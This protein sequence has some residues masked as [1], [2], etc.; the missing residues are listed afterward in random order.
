MRSSCTLAMQRLSDGCVRHLE[1]ADCIKVR[2]L[3]GT[4]ECQ[5]PA[6][7]QA[8]GLFCGG[9]NEKTGLGPVFS[10]RLSSIRELVGA[11][12]FEPATFSSRTRRATKLRYAPKMARILPKKFCCTR[13]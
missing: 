10:D 6:A 8:C 4:P 3:S 13:G 7:I 12:G 5:K 11:T 2:P 9:I 1:W